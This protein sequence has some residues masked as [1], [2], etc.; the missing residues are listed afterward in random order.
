M[1]EMSFDTKHPP[2]IT[3]TRCN[4]WLERFNLDALNR[5]PT[6]RVWDSVPQLS[7]SGLKKHMA[8]IQRRNP[9]PYSRINN[10]TFVLLSNLTTIY[11]S[12]CILPEQMFTVKPTDEPS[13]NTRVHASYANTVCIKQVQITISSRYDPAS[14]RAVEKLQEAPRT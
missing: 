2:S 1:I 10:S 4:E 12:T 8:F 3:S 14:A 6:V 7:I 11:D 5:I 13:N 9:T